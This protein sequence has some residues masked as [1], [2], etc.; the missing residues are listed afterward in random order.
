LKHWSEVPKLLCQVADIDEGV[1]LPF[2]RPVRQEIAAKWKWEWENNGSLAV[3]KLRRH[4]FELGQQIRTAAG[5]LEDANR[6]LSQLDRAVRAAGGD[7]QRQ[8]AAEDQSRVGA[9]ASQLSDALTKFEAERQD[10]STLLACFEAIRFV[11]DR[12]LELNPK[13]AANA[14]AGPP[15]LSYRTSWN[16]L[17]PMDKEAA[18]SREA[19][20]HTLRAEAKSERETSID[21]VVKVMQ[22]LADNRPENVCWVDHI[23]EWLRQTPPSKCK[24]VLF[25]R[26]K[27]YYLKQTLEEM[28]A[29]NP[30]T[31]EGLP[32]RIA[33]QFF[34]YLNHPSD[35]DKAYER[36][37]RIVRKKARK[38]A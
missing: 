13:T 33:E 2:I 25:L 4:I 37:D 9:K 14:L 23:E 8:R 15:E 27:W 20:N 17:R 35:F 10:C 1:I 16:R 3:K 29:R 5:D 18:E 21:R 36:E 24:E 26:K 19:E 22:R 11:R 6:R 30:C 32:R 28:D 12:W 38:R 31:A 7:K 34:E